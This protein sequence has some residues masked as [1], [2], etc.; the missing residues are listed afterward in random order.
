MDAFTSTGERLDELT[1]GTAATM[2]TVVEDKGNLEKY[3]S[4]KEMG[5]VIVT[6]L[7]TEQ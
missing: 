2:L 3:Y 5:K 1:D 7:D 4:L 6:R